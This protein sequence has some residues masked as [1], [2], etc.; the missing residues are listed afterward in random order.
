MTFADSHC[1]LTDPQFD[2]DRKAVIERARA[3]GVSCFIVIGATGDFSHNPKAVA[4]AQEHADVFAVVGVHPHD[5]KT[6]TAD[7]YARLRELVQEPRVV[8]LG[9][10]GLDFYYDNSPREDQRTHFRAFIRLARE[11]GLP[12]SMHVRD[13]YDEAAHTLRVEGER[14]VRGVMHCFTGSVEDA[15]AFLDLGLSLS[16]SGIITFKN[17]HALREVARI[18]PLDRLLIETDCPLLAPAPYRGKRNEPA[19]VV[20]VAKTVADVKGLALAEVAEAARRNTEALFCLP[21]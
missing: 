7:T 4:L 14:Q 10:T 16:F 1:H 17:A 12:L 2:N 19:Y 9:E 5:A 21:V 18:V 20:Q 13:A 11:L 3:A 15:R 8:G 6:I